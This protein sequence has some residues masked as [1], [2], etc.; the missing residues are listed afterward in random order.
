MYVYIL[1][2]IHNTVFYTGVTNNILRRMFEHKS[3][4]INGFSSK[5]QCTLLVWYTEISGETEAIIL[6][7]R[8]KKYSRSRKLRLITKDN[9]ELI[10]LAGDWEF[11]D[12]T[13]PVEYTHFTGK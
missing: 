13:V 12:L 6:E 9:P 5:Y 8:L 2:N 3:G 1:T 10:D 4:L 11:G 7:K